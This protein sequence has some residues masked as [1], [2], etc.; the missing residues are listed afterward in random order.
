MFH[1]DHNDRFRKRKKRA[2]S[3]SRHPQCLVIHYLL[4]MNN[5]PVPS[6]PV[7]HLL[8]IDNVARRCTYR[9]FQRRAS[10]TQ[11]TSIIAGII[12]RTKSPWNSCNVWR[13]IKLLKDQK[14]SAYTKMARK[15]AILISNFL[16]FHGDS[17]GSWVFFRDQCLLTLSVPFPLYWAMFHAEDTDY[18]TSIQWFHK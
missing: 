6:N 1:F 10:R 2:R 16:S 3:I 11:S 13:F 8:A 4:P 14:V 15:F 12:Y 5:L 17:R 7:F 18:P 9:F